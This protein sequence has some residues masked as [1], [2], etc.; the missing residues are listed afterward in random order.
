MIA[1]TFYLPCIANYLINI[2]KFSVSTASLFFMIPKIF[3]VTILQLL[4]C[5]SSKIGLYGTSSLGLFLTALGG[6]LI[7]PLISILNNIFILLLDLDF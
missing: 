2:Y 4:D 3:Y 7:A 6:F 5:I 1:G